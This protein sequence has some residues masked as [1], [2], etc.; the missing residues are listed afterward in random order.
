MPNSWYESAVLKGSYLAGTLSPP[1]ALVM[2]QVIQL[3][4]L[5]FVESM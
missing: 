5:T 2:Q 3:L 4:V 1:E